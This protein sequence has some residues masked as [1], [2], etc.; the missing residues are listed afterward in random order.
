MIQDQK[1][2]ANSGLIFIMQKHEISDQIRTG[3]TKP[4]HH[5]TV[6]NS[7][8]AIRVEKGGQRIETMNI[9]DKRYRDIR[10]KN[11]VKSMKGLN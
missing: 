10:K 8:V 3:V 6:S 11:K 7:A 2:D 1:L 4:K 9:Y 5:V